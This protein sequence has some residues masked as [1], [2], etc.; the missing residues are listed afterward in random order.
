V[1]AAPSWVLQ[2]RRSP[3]RHRRRRAYP[4]EPA[5]LSSTQQNQIDH[6]V[7]VAP[8]VVEAGSAA[9]FEWALIQRDDYAVVPA[10]AGAPRL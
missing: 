1:F 6:Q 4:L 2:C 8:I 5:V 10:N 3:A 7:E 9:I